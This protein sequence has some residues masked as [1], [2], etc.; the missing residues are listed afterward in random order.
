[1]VIAD[2]VTGELQW[3][4]DFA[5]TMSMLFVRLARI[6]LGIVAVQQSDGTTVLSRK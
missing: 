5:R 2:A 6:E 3:A 4:G 1:L